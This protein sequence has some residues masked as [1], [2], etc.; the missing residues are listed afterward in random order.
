MPE[1][2][3]TERQRKYF[4]TLRATLERDTGVTL[5][6]WAEIA[7]ACPHTAPRTRLAWMKEHHGLAQNRASLVLREAFADRLS[8]ANPDALFATL[9]AN[10][11]S[12]AIFTAVDAI[13]SAQPASIRTVRKGYVAWSGQFQF[14]AARPLSGGR[15][16]LGL[17]LAPQVDPRLEAPRNEPW[18]ERLKSRLAIAAPEEVGPLAS[19][20]ERARER[21]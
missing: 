8:W 12:L 16:V 21:S 5:E 3:L 14:A 1:P 13:S 9:W 17:A 11:D 18:S 19:L 10:P 15:L 7:R 20:L 2:A 6:G 4:A